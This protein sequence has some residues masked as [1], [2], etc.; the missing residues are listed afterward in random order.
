MN[1]QT[2]L[3]KGQ[4]FEKG[5]KC[6][7]NHSSPMSNTA[8]CNLYAK[9]DILKIRDICPNPKFK[10]QKQF[11]LHLDTFSWMELD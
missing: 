8:W 4:K 7:N 9:C 3:T 6:E 1:K 2:K 10:C 5:A 11:T